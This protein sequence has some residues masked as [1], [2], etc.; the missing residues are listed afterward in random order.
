MT[1]SLFSLV[2]PVYNEREN[3]KILIP[4]LLDNFRNRNIEIII[5][6]DGSTD[7]TREE[8]EEFQ[9]R[10]SNARIV[11]IKRDSL[12][13]IGS[14]LIDGY[15]A[16]SGAYIISCDADLSFPVK[17]IVDIANELEANTCDLVLGCRHT[18]GSYYE[19]P[20]YRIFSKKLVSRFGNI[21]LR[22]FTG[23]PIHDFSANCRGIKKSVWENLALKSRDNFML[24]EMVWRSYRLGFRV[25]EIPVNFYDRKF[26][27]SKLRLGRAALRFFVQFW[28][29]KF[30]RAGFEPRG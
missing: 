9:K 26:G 24:F 19:A 13:G 18:K 16:A 4:E 27:S 21:F 28:K 11:L 5:V 2:F 6:D 20:N 1:S 10:P 3:I 12:G 25:K 29:L 17:S 8:I 22:L 15:N 14:A 23:I 30:G 7:G